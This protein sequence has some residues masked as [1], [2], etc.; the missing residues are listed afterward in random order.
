MRPAFFSVMT[1]LLP[2]VWYL[3]YLGTVQFGLLEFYKEE[4]IFNKFTG[5]G[6]P[7]LKLFFFALKI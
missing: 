2:E 1:L 5:K 6:M 7:F 4:D 3:L